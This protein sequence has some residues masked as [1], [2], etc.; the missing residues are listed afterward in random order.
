MK[1]V[2]LTPD[3]DT[4]TA[5]IAQLTIDTNYTPDKHFKKRSS[6]KQ[7]IIQTQTYT[8]YYDQTSASNY[9]KPASMIASQAIRGS[10]IVYKHD[11]DFTIADFR[12][13]FQKN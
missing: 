13:A 9:N 1:C 8:I 12:C 5:I 6:S 2:V 7:I 3:P 11:I 4:D 10:A